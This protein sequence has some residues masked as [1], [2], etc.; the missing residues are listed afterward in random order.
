MGPALQAAFLVMN[1]IGGK[2]LLFQVRR[3]CWCVLLLHYA[4]PPIKGLLLLL[5][6]LLLQDWLWHRAGLLPAS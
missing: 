3:W 4:V 6:P 2:L 5:L 1:H